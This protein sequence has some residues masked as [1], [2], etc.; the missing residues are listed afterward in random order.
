[1]RFGDDIL[2][3]PPRRVSLVK[4]L[5]VD[6]GAM[7]ILTKDKEAPC[8]SVWQGKKVNTIYCFGDASKNG[9]EAAVEVERKGNVWRSGACN[10]T[11]R[12]ESSNYW[13]FKNLVE[14]IERLVANGMLAC[15]E[16]FMFA[17]NLMVEVAFFEGTST[18]KKLFN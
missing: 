13:K 3:R 5:V 8:R 12:E 6:V 11:M 14:T 16:L 18:R 15:H 7:I 4:P 1:L 9:F 17:D 2:M 10:V